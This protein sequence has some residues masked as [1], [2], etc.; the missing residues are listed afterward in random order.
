MPTHYANPNE[1]QVLN[2]VMSSELSGRV[3]PLINLFLGC[4]Y[5]YALLRRWS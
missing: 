2:F 5:C 1:P 4:V 3:A